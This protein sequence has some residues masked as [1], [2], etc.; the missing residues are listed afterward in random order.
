MT[1]RT[2]TWS[3]SESVTTPPAAKYVSPLDS[4]GVS[5]ASAGL[6]TGHGLLLGA[7]LM[8]A[9]AGVHLV[10]G[11]PETATAQ[12]ATPASPATERDPPDSRAVD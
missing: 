1:V 9:G 2:A 12:A 4:S 11:A 5:A 10:S 6:V 7:G 8:L 3:R